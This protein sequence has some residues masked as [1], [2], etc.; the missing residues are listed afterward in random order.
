MT[1]V[2]ERTTIDYWLHVRNFAAEDAS[3]GERISDA[4][5]IAFAEDKAILQA[6]QAEEDR[7]PDRQ[8]VRIAIDAGANRL[9]KLIGELKDK[10]TYSAAAN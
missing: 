1:P 4:F 8:P 3:V 10:E 6:V 2:D 9:R 5:R 7:L